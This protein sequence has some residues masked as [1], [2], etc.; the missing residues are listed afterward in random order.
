MRNQFKST[1]LLYSS[2][3]AS[4][5][6]L[7][8]AFSSEFPPPAT[9]HWRATV[10]SNAAVA[11]SAWTNAYGRFHLLESPDTIR[12][13]YSWTD[14]QGSNRTFTVEV[15]AAARREAVEAGSISPGQRRDFIAQALPNV[16]AECPQILEAIRNRRGPVHLPSYGTASL[17]ERTRFF[18]WLEETE[19]DYLAAAGFGRDRSGRLTVE[20]CRFVKRQ[21][22]SVK[23]IADEM[24]QR[25]AVEK[26]TWSALVYRAMSLVH[27]M[28]YEVPPNLEGGRFIYGIWSPLDA[29]CRGRGDCDTKAVL[30]S[31]VVNH[32]QDTRCAVV[33]IPGHAFNGMLGWHKRLPSDFVLQHR[34][35]DLLLLDI[36]D[37]STYPAW[38]RI[39]GSDRENLREKKPEVY[40]TW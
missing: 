35:V 23:P 40:E 2:A 38:A 24:I 11:P 18:Q 39:H 6:W 10:H 9:R 31:S 5:L 30:F 21:M 1:C 25:G 8:F 17:S 4:F 20:Y 28:E 32:F 29:F 22:P 19:A 27:C 33:T 3:V 13:L 37:F 26:I 7:T 12:P 16:E 34:G 36:T 15:G 14:Y